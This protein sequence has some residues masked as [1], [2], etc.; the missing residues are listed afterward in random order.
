MNKG[1]GSILL[2]LLCLAACLWANVGTH[3][4]EPLATALTFTAGQRPSA[5]GLQLV[6]DPAG[7]AMLRWVAG[8]AVL[9]PPVNRDFFR[10]SGVAFRVPEGW[11]P[12]GQAAYL[13]IEHMDQNLGLIQ[14]TYDAAGEA[15]ASRPES[16]P[17]LTGA[18]ALAGYTCLG[19]NQLRLAV[20]RLDRPGFHHRQPE[21]AD[22]RIAGVQ[23]L[24]SITLHRG[25]P[26]SDLQKAR[27][28]VPRLMPSR[29]KLTKPI[30][31]VTAI[32]ADAS[33]VEELPG[34]IERIREQAPLAAAL[35][36]NGI[37]SYVK[38][39]FVE[40]ERGRFDWSFYDALVAEI[41]Q[42]GL[43]WFPL[44]VVGSAYTLPEWY[45]D[46]PLNVGFVC[47]EHHQGNTIQTI[48][49][50]NQTPYVQGFLKAFG[51][52]Y[53]FS[54]DLLGVR[55]GPSGNYGE[56]QYPA[57]G[58]WGY[59]GRTEHIH[60]GW[61]A[62]D[63]FANG[64]FRDF[65][66]AKYGEIEALNRA[67]GEKFSS[68]DQVETF[69]P[70]FAETKRKRKDLVDWYVGAMTDW[71]ERWAI[72]ARQAM[73]QKPIYQ[74]SGGWGFV[75][76][77]TDF[78]DQAKSMVKVRGGIRATNE[79]DSY[80]Q[81]FYATRMMSSA[82]R[83]YKVPF[84][85]EPAGYGSARGVVARLYNI[86]VNNGQHLFYYG[87]NVFDNDQAI[88]KWMELAPL[89]D[90]REDPFIEVAAL[91]PDTK[92]KLDDGVFRNLYSFAFNDRVAALR[93]LF[94]FDFCSEQMVR[95][96]AL[97]RYKVLL[98]LW[99]DIVE[100]DALEAIDRWVR[101]GGVVLYNYWS[102]MPL[103]TV[104][105]DYAVYNRWLR[106]DT[107]MG[108]VIWYRSD[109]EPP[110]R[111]ARFIRQQLLELQR[112]DPRTRRM[113]LIDKGPEV[114]V[115]VLQSGKLAIL[116]YNDEV[117]HALVPGAGTVSLQPYSIRL[118]QPEASKAA[119]AKDGGP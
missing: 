71:C 27:Q 93:P 97:S 83:F 110:S 102:R 39:N 67:W 113:L 111:Y 2:V 90:Q 106:G 82:A 57:G 60:I 10:R 100:A 40:P 33:K 23:S 44:L 5:A 18:A 20:F 80:A 17:E 26:E 37:E 99:S 7:P 4:A 53:G 108:K 15:V 56:S 49:C 28:G 41:R 76:S 117:A 81:N 69:I 34:A 86:M 25:L 95:D 103:S 54:L 30:H 36:F 65:L 50:E 16:R 59:K 8:K 119:Q 112:L 88:P 87:S 19:T 61:W 64:H 114:Y 98:F 12:L 62:G 63:R 32:G 116:N 85:S 70:Q 42:F 24:R 92:G 105:E 11:N 107:G 1:R 21:R 51:A 22:F 46:S 29:L 118:V 45:H 38:W 115:S 31:L 55:L 3:A 43:R 77:G 35:G 89:L 66:K 47:L 91:Y 58:N 74:S 79:T 6:A 75:E 13:V 14:V 84:G 104:E 48:F 96:G 78:T 72:W 73:P 109:R 68:F 101:H 9:S 52:H 94:D